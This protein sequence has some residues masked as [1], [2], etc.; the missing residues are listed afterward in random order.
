MIRRG[1]MQALRLMKNPQAAPTLVKRLDDTD[2]YVR[3]L[4]VIS[5]A[6]TFG[7]YEDYAPSMYLFD[8]NPGFYISLWKD[9]WAHE[10]HVVPR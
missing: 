6:E 5:L 3:Y 1:A 8:D 4:A 2:G 9:W 10:G 7:K